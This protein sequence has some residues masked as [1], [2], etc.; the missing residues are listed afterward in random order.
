LI[1]IKA[2]ENAIDI[3]S[4]GNPKHFLVVRHDKCEVQHTILLSGNSD[5]ELKFESFKD[6]N[7]FLIVM[8]VMHR[9]THYQWK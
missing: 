4:L 2:F 7:S 6:L 5:F 9:L 8:K 1:K 3:K